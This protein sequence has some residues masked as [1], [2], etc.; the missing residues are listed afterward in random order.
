MAN[1][2]YLSVIIPVYNEADLLPSTLID[3]DKYLRKANFDYEVLIVND[4]SKDNTAEI[5][6]NF[7]PVM[8][9]LRLVNNDIHRGRGY[10]VR[11][12]IQEAK[13]ELRL[14]MD[15]DNS[16]NIDHFSQILPYFKDTEGVKYDIVIGSRFMKKSQFIPMPSLYRRFLNSAEG[17]LVRVLLLPGIRDARCG[18]KCFSEDSAKRIFP[19]AK[20]NRS[21]A[22]IEVL[23]LGSKMG[24]KIKEIPIIYINNTLQAVKLLTY[25][26][27]LCDVFRIKARIWLGRYKVNH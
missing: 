21:S 23:T 1:K 22:D 17:V 5:V 15:I 9:K 27:I 19:L 26:A 25:C 24:F 2:P 16:I 20:I 10:V 14:L 3:I 8:Q 18:F 6:R 11:H 12:G 13:G 7:E 4:G